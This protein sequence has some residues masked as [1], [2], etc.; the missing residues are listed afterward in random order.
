M[1]WFSFAE[2]LPLVISLTAVKYFPQH[3]DK[4]MLS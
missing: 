3:V 4:D 2:V 1:P